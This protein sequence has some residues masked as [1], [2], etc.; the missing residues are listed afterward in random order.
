MTT[1]YYIL[2]VPLVFVGWVSV[3]GTVGLYSDDAP[4]YV[5]PF[6]TDNFLG[7]LPESASILSIDTLSVTLTSE[8]PGFARTLYKSGAFI[9]LP[10]GL[11]GCAP[12]LNFSVRNTQV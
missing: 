5:V 9:V 1:R 10:S 11:E 7:N 6:P 8:K 2:A 12:N 3:L 4:A